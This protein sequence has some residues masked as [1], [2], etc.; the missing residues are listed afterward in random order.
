MSDPY[1]AFIDKYQ[2]KIR[3]AILKVWEELR[4]SVSYKELET[5]LV[6]EGVNGVMKY[7]D[8]LEPI[9]RA[10]LMP[11]LQQAMEESGR[12]VVDILPNGSITTPGYIPSVQFTNP[13]A[14][15]AV[16]QYSF[17][18]I[19]ELSNETREAVRLAVTT[20]VSQGR[21]PAAIA[22]DY[23]QTIGLTVEQE[24][25]VQ[26][27]RRYLETLDR[28]ALQ[29]QSRDKRSDSTVERAI[30]DEKSLP[31][32]TVDKLVASFR[33]KREAERSLTIAR[34]ESMSAMDLGQDMALNQ[35]NEDGA[36]APDLIQ[37]WNVTLDG[38][39]REEH[40]VTP[41]LNPDGVPYGEFFQTPLGPMRYP[42]DRKYGTAKNVINC[43]CRRSFKRRG[44]NTG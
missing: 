24:K 30:R 22:R 21:P 31:K 3:E 8:N 14:V 43:R 28:Q 29:R 11:E 13:Y 36:L 27:Y 6:T 2:P 35:T 16:Q 9:T 18:L 42:R 26:N 41:S 32:A 15:Q 10:L 23:K 4:K 1:P 7:L 44:G 40:Q 39:E 12:L 25:S 34:T 17:N 38:R 5:A 20:A 19:R 33:R 37:F